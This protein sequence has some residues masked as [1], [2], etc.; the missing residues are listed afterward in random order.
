MLVDIKLKKFTEIANRFIAISLAVLLF[1]SCAAIGPVPGNLMFSYAG[2]EIS[3]EGAIGGVETAVPAPM[4]IGDGGQGIRLAVIAP[5]TQGDVP[6]HLP[7]LVQGL[8]NNNFG[9]YSRITIIDRQH[10]DRIISEQD[11]AAGGRFSEDDFISI[12]NLTNTQYNLFG[13]ILRLGGE[14]FNLQLSITELGS[15]IRRATSMRTGSLAQLERGTLINEATEDLLTQM[16]V[17][18]TESGRQS[19][20]AGNIAMVRAETGIARGITAQAD[21][22]EVGAMFNIIQ[23]VTFDPG[24]IEAANRLITLSADISGGTISER[25]VGDIEQRNRWLDVFRETTRFFNDHPPFEITFDP[26]L[27][28]IGETDFVRNTANIG[29][30]I[31]L[32]PSEAG[33]RA[34][35]SLLDGLVRTGRRDGWGFSGWP[36]QNIEPRTAGTVVFGGNHSFSYRVD[37]ALINERNQNLGSRRIT[38]TTEIPRFSPGHTVVQTPHEVVELVEFPNIRSADLTPTLRIVIVAVNGVSSSD[39]YASGYMRIDTGDLENRHRD[40]RARIAREQAAA[41]AMRAQRRSNALN[42]ALGIGIVGGLLGLVIWGAIE[43]S[44]Q[45]NL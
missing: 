22:D 10:L 36:L 21:G 37:V 1:A 17:A 15:G 35:N 23:A 18:L 27:I 5:E 41:T 11:I 42:I 16:G 32:S 33:F 13:T 12:G 7:I 25:I 29:M 43:Y 34:L 40:Y 44:G 6:G 26:N 24:N 28:Q 3:A 30:R 9:R 31:A 8:L 4:F 39:L 45:E 14:Q 19:L 20:L 2:T 38:L